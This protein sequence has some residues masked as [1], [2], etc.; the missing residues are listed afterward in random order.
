M[1]KALAPC[2]T[3]AAYNR[4]RRRGEHPDDACREAQRVYKR[5]NRA[6][7]YLRAAQRRRARAA[8]CEALAHMFPQ[9]FARLLAM[10]MEEELRG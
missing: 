7:L 5:Q 10:A 1:K 2:G 8:A 3:Y 4:H 9:Q 6:A